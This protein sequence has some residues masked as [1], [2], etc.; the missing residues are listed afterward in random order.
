MTCT[1]QQPE[2]CAK[3]IALANAAADCASELDSLQAS[4]SWLSPDQH[5]RMRELIERTYAAAEAAGI[6]IGGEVAA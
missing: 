1:C 4:S 3:K 2:C 5:T 6:T